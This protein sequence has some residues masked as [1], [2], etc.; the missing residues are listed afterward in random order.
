MVEMGLK[1]CKLAKECNGFCVC[2]TPDM[3]GMK[4]GVKGKAQKHT[5]P[6]FSGSTTSESKMFN[7][8][9]YNMYCLGGPT[10]L[11]WNLPYTFTECPGICPNFGTKN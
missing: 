10:T 1:R 8:F 5:K 6:D 7:K 2:T 9:E 11:K 3:K 4:Q